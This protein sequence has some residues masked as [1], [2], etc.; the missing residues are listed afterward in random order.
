MSHFIGKINLSSLLNV[1]IAD[2]EQ[3]GRTVKCLV[4]PIQDNGIQI[5]N[6]ELQLW[7]RAFAYREKRGKFSH[8]L[9]KYI[10]MKDIKKLSAKQIETFANSSI[11]AMMKTGAKEENE[12]ETLNF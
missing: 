2:V 8:F 12:N 4:I 10:P 6:D 11:G 1:S 3:C 7:F 5:W 9:M